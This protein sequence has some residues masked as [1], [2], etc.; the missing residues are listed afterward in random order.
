MCADD[1]EHDFKYSV[2][3]LAA[4]VKYEF[5]ILLLLKFL[6]GRRSVGRLVSGFKETL[7]QET[8]ILQVLKEKK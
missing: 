1:A 4:Y 7:Q 8:K 5:Q 2:F 6:N 3:K